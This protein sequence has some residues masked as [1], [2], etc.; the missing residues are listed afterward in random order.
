M[1]NQ[2][3]FALFEED[4]AVAELKNIKSKLL[5]L[6][7]QYVREAELSQ[8]EVSEIVGI[9]KPRVSNLMKGYLHKFSVDMLLTVAIKLGHA[10]ETDYNPPSQVFTLQVG[11][12]K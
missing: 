9:T 5:M 8:S 10:V 7:I 3:V 4:Q 6:I 11:K 12:V 2:N 1:T